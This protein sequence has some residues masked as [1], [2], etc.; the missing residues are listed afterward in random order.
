MAEIR[1]EH[2]RANIRSQESRVQSRAYLSSLFHCTAAPLPPLWHITT[3]PFTITTHLCGRSG[4]CAFRGLLYTLA[5]LLGDY[6]AV[7]KGKV[8]QRVGC[9]AAGKATDKAVRKLFKE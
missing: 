3:P 2:R 9:W 4:K 5:K 6:N 7:N 8:G 1:P